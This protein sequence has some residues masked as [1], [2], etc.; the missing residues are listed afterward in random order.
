MW[1]GRPTLPDGL[2]IKAEDVDNVFTATEDDHEWSMGVP[3][4]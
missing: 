1:E 2:L 4:Q 3:R